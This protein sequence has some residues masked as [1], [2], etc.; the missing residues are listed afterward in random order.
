MTIFISVCGSLKSVHALLNRGQRNQMA[1]LK[2]ANGNKESS[3]IDS[4][5]NFVGRAH[6][7]HRFWIAQAQSDLPAFT[8]KF[9][10]S[11]QVRNTAV[12]QPGDYTVTV[13]NYG[14]PA[15]AIVRDSAGRSVARFMCQILD[16]QTS[17]RNEL[18]LRQKDGQ[19]R[20]Y[21]LNLGNLGTT[22]VY[23]PALA[24]EAALDAR[25][26]QAVPVIVAKR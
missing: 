22:L 17:A 3:G 2:K 6:H 18:F 23:D 26:T 9:R 4:Q 1:A 11:T 15:Y 14:R 7:C 5:Q 13:E 25:V 20:V 8:G 21:G 24:R 12:L 19:F 16:E 10:L